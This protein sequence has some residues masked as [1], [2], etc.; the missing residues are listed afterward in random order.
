MIRSIPAVLVAAGL[1]ASAQSQ[2]VI[3]EVFENPPGQAA[4]N[5]AVL[6][7][8]EFYGQPGM[9]LDGYAIGLVKG[10]IDGNGD[11][12]PD[13]FAEIDEAF[14]LDGF[15]LDSNGLFVLYNGTP[16]QSLV[17][18]FLPPGA[19][20]G[21]F[22]D[23]HIPSPEPDGNGNL[24]N[25]GSSTYLLVRA[26]PNYSF[27]LGVS[28]YSSGYAFAKDN[29]P[30]VDFDGKLDFG[31][32]TPVPNVLGTS[33]GSPVQSDPLQIIDEIAWSNG[34]GKEYVRSS[35]QEISDT[36]G[37]NP[38]AVSRLSY[39]GENPMLG[40]R[41]NGDNETVPTRTADEE[42]I[43]GEVVS[44][45]AFFEYD[46]AEVGAPTDPEG[47]GFA[48]LS[49]TSG[50][51][52]FPMTPGAFNDFSAGGLTQFRFVAGDLDF[53]GDADCDDLALLDSALLN[54]DLDAT[55]DFIDD[56]TGLPVPD[57]MNPGQNLRSFVFQGRLANAFLAA[58]NL[59]Q[60]DGVGGTNAQTVTTT[61]R[62]ALAALVGPCDEP[63]PADLAAPAGVLDFFDVLAYL[64]QFDA[65]D[66]AA[67]LAAPFGT[68]DFFD[69]LEYLGLF[70]AGC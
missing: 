27:A 21:S 25:D 43:Y 2:V 30:D 3:N 57:P 51:S 19:A 39:F 8:I 20:S 70:D 6:E 46:P 16:S 24:A 65:Q 38:D 1:A 22:F 66:P 4:V 10:G 17:P 45:G 12:I 50:S 53:D 23:T 15:S 41:L 11:N 34:G 31:F 36:P 48:D 64:G 33:P 47:D 9:S 26:R 32:E 42:F 14:T 18:I 63:C 58:S 62:D 59:D 37:F 56:D 35:E 54:A 49:I 69:V 40:F 44:A 5:D 13:G 7:Y 29:N 52:N 68:F 60:T 55:E 28:T 61:D 67:D